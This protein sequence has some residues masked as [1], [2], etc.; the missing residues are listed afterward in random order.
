MT[1]SAAYETWLGNCFA[2]FAEGEPDRCSVCGRV[3]ASPQ[4]QPTAYD[5]GHSCCDERHDPMHDHFL[6][7]DKCPACVNG[8]P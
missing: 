5:C 4:T 8:T 3:N 6:A 1:D 7:A 2:C